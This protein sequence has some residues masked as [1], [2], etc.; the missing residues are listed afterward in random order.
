LGEGKLSI[1]C[2]LF[3]SVTALSETPYTVL[4]R[5]NFCSICVFLIV[6]QYYPSLFSISTIDFD[7]SSNNIFSH[8]RI[9][10][11]IEVMHA[12]FIRGS[13]EENKAA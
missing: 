1:F 13:S 9:V 2:H 10:L 6:H 7:T 4:A 12:I 8:Y 5:Q 11:K 3:I